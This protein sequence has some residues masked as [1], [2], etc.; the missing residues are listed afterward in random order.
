MEHRPAGPLEANMAAEQ[1]SQMPAMFAAAIGTPLRTG[2]S[3]LFGSFML[4]NILWLG[5]YGGGWCAKRW[6]L[7]RV[8]DAEEEVDE[9]EVAEEAVGEDDVG[10][11]E[12]DRASLRAI[13]KLNAK[14]GREKVPLG[15]HEAEDRE[16][17]TQLAAAARESREV[18]SRTRMAK[19]VKQ[20][21]LSGK[22]SRGVMFDL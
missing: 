22:L 2:L 12:V 6:R 17:D 8:D 4:F 1:P 18:R 9:E 21:R 15:E 3:I 14:K 19:L 11:E 10:V 16:G 7:P 5:W 20:A 13:R